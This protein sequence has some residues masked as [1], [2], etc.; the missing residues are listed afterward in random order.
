MLAFG[1]A[2]DMGLTQNANA[3]DVILFE[4]DFEPEPEN[5]WRHGIWH[6]KEDRWSYD[7]STDSITHQVTID[8]V[9]P[10]VSIDS[11]ISPVTFILPGDRLEFMS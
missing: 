4:D 1:T 6:G 9:A 2:L 11:M 3:S 7:G 10:T 5:G 8:N